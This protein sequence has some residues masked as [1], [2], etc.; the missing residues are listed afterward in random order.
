VL[1][2]AMNSMGRTVEKLDPALYS[3]ECVE[4]EFSEV[5]EL[6]FSEVRLIC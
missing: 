6:E 4:G 5:R 3:P 1:S 2:G